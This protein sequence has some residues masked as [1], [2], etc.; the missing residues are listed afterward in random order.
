MRSY[1]RKLNTTKVLNFLDWEKARNL[2]LEYLDNKA[3]GVPNHKNPNM[4]QYAPRL[5]L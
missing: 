2:Y 4:E 5:S 1:F 3:K